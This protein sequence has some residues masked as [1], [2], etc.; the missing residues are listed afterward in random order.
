[1]LQHKDWSKE[2]TNNYIRHQHNGGNFFDAIFQNN[3]ILVTPSDYMQ[4]A[5]KS[6]YAWVSVHLLANKYESYS[7]ICFHKC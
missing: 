7:T 6:F 3:K 1:M 5:L 2:L 4:Y